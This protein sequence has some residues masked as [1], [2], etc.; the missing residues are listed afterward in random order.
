MIQLAELL[1]ITTTLSGASLHTYVPQPSMATC[2]ELAAKNAAT[3]IVY[4]SAYGESVKSLE[5]YCQDENG[6]VPVPER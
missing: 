2:F 4:H 6:S 3:L 5:M 1:I